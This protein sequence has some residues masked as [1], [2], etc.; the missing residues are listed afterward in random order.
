MQNLLPK[1]KLRVL[2]VIAILG[3]SISAGVAIG[4]D[5]A[6]LL[7]ALHQLGW[8]GSVMVLGLSAI[9]YVMR[10]LRWKVY[11]DKLG[12]Q[13]PWLYHTLCY[14]GGFA[15]TVSPAKAGEAVRS[16][17]L[18]R[19]DVPYAESISVLFVERLLD[20][21]SIAILASFIVL[22]D[23]NYRIYVIGIGIMVLSL[24]LLV[25]HRSLPHWLD[26]LNKNPRRW[27]KKPVNYLIGIL[28]S[29]QLLLHPRLLL[30]GVIVGLLSWGAE[31]LGFQ[32]ICQGLHLNINALE[33]VAIYA[34]AILAGS[35]AIFMPGGIGGT[36]IV[37][38]TL[39]VS[40]GATLSAAVI[41]TLLCRLATLWFAVV[42]G[43]CAVAHLEFFIVR[44]QIN[45]TA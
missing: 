41:A 11:V 15:F 27:L 14:L 10:F 4:A 30:F 37:M 25:C 8:I 18:R 22:Y 26:T 33:A 32:L 31:G 20:V 13:V 21:L 19:Y 7:E 40:R 38:T 6:R 23:S 45:S 2:I 16:I 24:L 17:Y 1:S 39:L 34:I 12:H 9:N 36:E 28:S 3:V 44:K 43:L 42:I 35:V 29:S 5:S